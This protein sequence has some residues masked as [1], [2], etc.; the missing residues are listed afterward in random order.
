MEDNFK[1]YIDELQNDNLKI[2]KS[3]SPD[4]LASSDPE[5][6]FVSPVQ[7][8]GYACIS[9]DFMIL[10]LQVNSSISMPCSICNEFTS[11]QVKVDFCHS[12][13]LKNIKNVFD[14]QEILRESIMIEIPLFTECDGNCPERANIK[15]YLKTNSPT[16]GGN[17]LYFPFSEIN[18]LKKE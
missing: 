18:N 10:R 7:I 9:E 17:L 14:F 6:K 15:K 2:E 8:V 4:F 5:L 1:I 12:E 11:F 3:L 13:E 16:K